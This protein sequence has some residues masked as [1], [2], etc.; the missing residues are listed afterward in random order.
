M[1]E[2]N[3]AE[4]RAEGASGLTPSG[5][6][7]PIPPPPPATVSL[8]PAT[9]SRWVRKHPSSHQ[10]EIESPGRGNGTAA[11]K[12]VIFPPGVKCELAWCQE[13]CPLVTNF[14]P[15]Q[16]D[17]LTRTEGSCSHYMQPLLQPRC[18]SR[19]RLP[20]ESRV[21]R[22][23][24]NDLSISVAAEANVT[25]INSLLFSAGTEARY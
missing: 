2:N 6:Q 25:S 17:G 4:L 14:T 5:P 18:H 1:E 10:P 23:R 16:R 20:S 11:E 8:D 15:G 19:I 3:S 13:S 9:C 21:M 22:W 24:N 12:I 7:T